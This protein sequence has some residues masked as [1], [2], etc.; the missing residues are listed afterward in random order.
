MICRLVLQGGNIEIYRSLQYIALIALCGL[1]RRVTV[2]LD[3]SSSTA[4]LQPLMKDN[5]YTF[6]ELPRVNPHDKV[7]LLN[8]PLQLFL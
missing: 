4:T 3:G 7:E 5:S 2:P 1:C 8:L 6:C